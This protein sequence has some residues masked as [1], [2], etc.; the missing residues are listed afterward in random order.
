MQSVKEL[1]NQKKVIIVG[2]G[3][4]CDWTINDH[5][6]DE[7]HCQISFMG[8]NKYLIADLGSRH[9]TYVNNEK[10]NH[11]EINENDFVAIGSKIFQLKSA[12]DTAQNT[13]E[14]ER[15]EAASIY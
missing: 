7:K 6:I 12:Y 10:I 14:K 13:Q 2:S 1:I 9:G 4:L 5:L 8:E 11:K 15:V 3:S